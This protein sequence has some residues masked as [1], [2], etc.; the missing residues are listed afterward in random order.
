MDFRCFLWQFWIY[1][2]LGL[3]LEQL[4]A[5]ALGRRENRRCRLLLP[6]CP[7]YALGALAILALP[8]CL[9]ATPLGLALWG[10][11]AATAAEYAAHLFY[12]FF[13][14]VSFWDYRALWGN[15]HGRVCLPFSLGWGVLA[16]LALPWAERLIAPLAA[17]P[18]PTLTF[19]LLLVF[20]ADTVASFYYLAR[21]GAPFPRW[22]GPRRSYLG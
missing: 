20:T 21:H 2:A 15:L 8:R 19:A 22:G 18:G 9:T 1:S 12:D 17:R 16:A 14:G 5:A 13:L 4:F 10:G 11:L 3:L 6:I 7:V